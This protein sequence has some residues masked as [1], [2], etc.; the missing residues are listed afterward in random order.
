MASLFLSYVLGVWLL[1][2]QFPSEITAGSLKQ[3]SRSICTNQIVDHI[4]KK[5]TALRQTDSSVKEE[6]T[7][8]EGPVSE[9]PVII[10]QKDAEALK[11]LSKFIPEMP[12]DL[13]AAFSD[14]QSLL[15]KLQHPK[16]QNI[17][18]N[19]FSSLCC[20]VNWSGDSSCKGQEL[21]KIQVEPGDIRSLV[22]PGGKNGL[23][24]SIGA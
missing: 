17:L 8:P 24:P 10:S 5:C 6:V 2:G 21:L 12:Q 4:E 23:K 18:L 16:D 7:V 11:T 22:E 13:K 3:Q 1:L 9:E 20:L 14:G 15:R 19:A